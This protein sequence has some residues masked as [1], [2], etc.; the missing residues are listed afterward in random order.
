M[1]GF[2]TNLGLAAGRNILYGQEFQERQAELDLRK[3]QVEMGKLALG[4][5]QRQQQTQ[6]EVGGFL[7][8]EMQKDAAN[9]TDPANAA[10]EY[11]KASGIAFSEGDFVTGNAMLDLAKGKTVEAKNALIEQQKQLQMKK[12]DL[13]STA[14]AYADNPTPE[15]AQQL[16]QKA[17]AAGVNPT[18]IPP[19]LQSPAGR[20][21]V[22]EQ[23]MSSMSGKE[24]IQF[25]EK[26]AEFKANQARMEQAHRD[27]VAE[28]DATR[29]QTAIYQNGMLQLKAA[30]LEAKKERQ[31]ADSTQER[32]RTDA[33]IAA[34]SAVVRDL[35]NVALLPEGQTS[36]LLSHLGNKNDL[37]NAVSDVGLKQITPG[38]AQAYDAAMAG[39][40]LGLARMETA[41]GGRGANQSVINEFQ[42]IAASPAGTPNIVTLYKLANVADMAKNQLRVTRKSTD[43]NVQSARE[44]DEAFLKSVPTTAEVIAVA[45]KHGWQHLLTQG[46]DMQAAM[47][48]ITNTGGV[49]L[50]GQGGGGGQVNLPPLPAGGG[51]PPGVTVEIH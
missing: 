3:Q 24:R 22:N 37:L 25:L 39:I 21:W 35:R 16:V 12:E 13:S 19:N 30:E 43:P 14:G 33:T 32:G 51:L 27:S 40:G 34:A 48:K 42:R 49:G 47:D 41:K 8:S 45:R 1:A 15:N 11:N 17:I 46:G 18:T 50:P 6:A 20:K 23:T 2:L 9:F 5:A 31:G 29:R 44:E 26:A 4:N 7:Q 28:R 38:E 36:G 10:K